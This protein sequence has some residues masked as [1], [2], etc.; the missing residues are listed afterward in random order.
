VQVVIVG[1][2]P[3]AG[4]PSDGSSSQG[5]EAGVPGDGSSSQGSEAEDFEALALSHF[6]VNKTVMR[7]SPAQI[8]KKGLPE[9][10]A[11]TLL[12]VPPPAGASA[13]ALVC[14]HRTCLPPITDATALAEALENTGFVN[15]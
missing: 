15:L 1:S 2:G 12:H 4:V 11:E 9:A 10:L 3:E 13:W 5:S 14:R 8:V 6:A 7:I